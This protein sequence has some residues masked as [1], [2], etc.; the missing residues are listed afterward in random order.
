MPDTIANLGQLTVSNILMEI[1]GV[2]EVVETTVQCKRFHLWN[3]YIFRTL[4]MPIVY[5]RQFT[6]I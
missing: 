4:K 2:V 6:A 3:L 1:F 5:S